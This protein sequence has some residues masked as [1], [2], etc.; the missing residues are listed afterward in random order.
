MRI[1]RESLFSRLLGYVRPEQ[2]E[3]RS[4]QQVLHMPGVFRLVALFAVMVVVPSVFLAYYGARSIRGEELS[5][6]QEVQRE[7]DNAADGFGR[8]LEKDF[9]EF[10]AAVQR[11]LKSGLS[12]LESPR[13]LHR[14]LAVALRFNHD[15][16]LVAPFRLDDSEVFEDVAYLFEGPYAE[17]RIA[18]AQGLDPNVAAER[19]G[20]AAREA[21]GRAAQGR[22][23]FDRARML[24]RAGRIDEARTAF[25][26]IVVQYGN[27]RD[28]WGFRLGDLARL[29]HAEMLLGAVRSDEGTE[30][31]R[32][33][34]RDLL[35]T[36]WVVG[37]GAEPAVLR[38]AVDRLAPYSEPE[39][40]AST[41]ERI[42]ERSQQLYYAGELLGEIQE[43]MKSSE[44]R[45]QPGQ[46]SWR[47]GR[48]A[49]WATLWWGDDFYA[50]GFDTDAI[51]SELKADANGSVPHDSPVA[52]ALFSPNESLPDSQL[53]RRSLA[54]WLTGWSFVVTP[55]DP[56]AL[57]QAQTNRRNQR[58][59]IVLFALAMLVLGAVLSMR[60]VGRELDVAN[61]KTDFAASVSHELRS[62]ITQIRIK[63]EALLLGLADTDEERT[64]HYLT[65]V[66]ETERL[67]RLVDNTLDFSAIE[68]GAKSYMLRPGDLADTILRA[69]DGIVGSLELQGTSFDID[70]PADLPAVHHDSDAVVQ[71]IIN[72]VSNAAKYSDPG[73]TVRVSA[74]TRPDGGVDVAVAD[75]GI[76]MSAEDVAR[77]FEPFFRS[78]DSNARKRK[79]TGIGLTIARYIMRAHGGDI[80]VR[81]ELGKGSTFT[82]TFPAQPPSSA[83]NQ[84]W[85]ESFLS[86]TRKRSSRPS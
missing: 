63:A 20:A 18:E 24:A 14:H 1:D 11:R 86:R 68:R 15:L 56:V 48:K 36:R 8:N 6:V 9:G 42:E 49:L 70:V 52:A 85:R 53:V 22:A 60:L 5:V 3:V 13:R 51:L 4:L 41:R 31:L 35:A 19:Y 72:L 50:F 62:P 32:S 65:I 46:M 28:P 43:L 64:K 45:V 23:L 7:A 33:M 25:D 39:W 82:L 2:G 58:F 66:R 59:G 67:S 80:A 75:D 17:T 47:E 34:V 77:V 83:E 55:K 37:H 76:G 78:H 26:L 57:Q 27:V 12:P 10:E 29:A 38:K 30:V 73:S 44:L 79:G 54:P 71:C 16:E 61:M 21:R 69:C 81:S 40:V 74:Q 84:G